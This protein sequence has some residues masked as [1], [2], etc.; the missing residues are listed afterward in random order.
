MDRYVVAMDFYPLQ[1]NDEVTGTIKL[2][3]PSVF[4]P[5]LPKG[6]RLVKQSV[7]KG[8]NVFGLRLI[9][10]CDIEDIVEL[11][12]IIES[13]GVYAYKIDKLYS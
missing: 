10:A 13:L 9:C 2:E 5:E 8:G 1:K 7:L 11:K 3:V 6:M 12:K 4:T